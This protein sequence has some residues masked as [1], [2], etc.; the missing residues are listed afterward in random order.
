MSRAILNGIFSVLIV[1]SAVGCKTTVQAQTEAPA[2][3]SDATIVAKKNK[4]GTYAVSVDVTNLAPPSRLDAEATTFVVWLVT[5]DAPAV[6]AGALAYDEGDRRGRLETSSPSAQFN[7]LITLEKDS[8]PL[9]PSGKGILDVP[10]AT[11]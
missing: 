4:T 5:K 10:V 1:F 2:L 11:R 8:A 6:R 9:S 3:G 7:V